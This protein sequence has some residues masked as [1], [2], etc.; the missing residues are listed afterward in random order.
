[1][2]HTISDLK[3]IP[4]LEPCGAE[5]ITF[6]YIADGI[7][8]VGSFDADHLMSS[9]NNMFLKDNVIHGIS[10]EDFFALIRC[11]RHGRDLFKYTRRQKSYEGWRYSCTPLEDYLPIGSLVDWEWMRNFQPL[12]GTEERIFQWTVPYQPQIDRPKLEERAYHTFSLYNERWQ[13]Q[14]VC[15]FNSSQNLV[16]DIEFAGKLEYPGPGP[17]AGESVYYRSEREFAWRLEDAQTMGRPVNPVF[18]HPQDYQIDLAW[19][20]GREAGAVRTGPLS[21]EELEEEAR[22]VVDRLCQMTE[23]DDS[24]I[25]GYYQI[26]LSNLI[27]TRAT[28]EDLDS[29]ICRLPMADVIYQRVK[30]CDAMREQYYLF[31]PHKHKPDPGCGLSEKQKRFRDD[32]G[33]LAKRLSEVEDL[34]REEA[35]SYFRHGE[36]YIHHGRL[37]TYYR[38]QART[39]HGTMHEEGRFVCGDSQVFV[40]PPDLGTLLPDV[41]SVGSEFVAVRDSR[42]QPLASLTKELREYV[43][44]QIQGGDTEPHK[45]YL[46]LEWPKGAGKSVPGIKP[47]EPA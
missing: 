43:M 1:M 34:I 15:R 41:S 40:Y 23:K 20:Y 44:Y 46:Y 25:E 18:L 19:G 3:Y 26:P 4:N 13:Y 11:I 29:I 2:V 5:K 14:G 22:L 30:V 32:N 45:Q 39:C 9:R 33:V 47:Q 6:S 37:Y 7:K 28:V 12:E 16:I 35:D 24:R 21:N 31:V 8:K 38:Y 36:E 27:N 42:F 17:M 10:N